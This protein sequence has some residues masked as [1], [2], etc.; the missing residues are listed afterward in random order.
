[1][2]LH[3]DIQAPLKSRDYRAAAQLAASYLDPHGLLGAEPSAGFCCAQ[4]DL[5]FPGGP[6]LRITIDAVARYRI[7]II[8]RD[9]EPGALESRL[10]KLRLAFAKTGLREQGW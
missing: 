10:C 8:A 1:M 5:P 4:V 3:T 2:S 6:T 7:D 9:R